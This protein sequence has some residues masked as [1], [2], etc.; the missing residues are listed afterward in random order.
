[1]G[2]FLNKSNLIK[3]GGVTIAV[4]LA[5]NLTAKQSKLIQGVAAVVAVAIALP[6][7]AKVGG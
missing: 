1:M 5:T 4:L 3:A 2:N 6:L 7:L